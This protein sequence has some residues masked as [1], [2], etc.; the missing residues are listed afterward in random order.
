[1]NFFKRLHYPVRLRV[2]TKLIRFMA[3]W[4]SVILLLQGCAVYYKS[5][6]T[7]EQAAEQQLPVKVHF[8][9]DETV[10]FRYILQ[11]DGVFYGTTRKSGEWSKTLLDAQ[12]VEN[13]FGKNKSAST[14][15]TIGVIGVP[16]VFLVI[17]IADA[18]A[19]ASLLDAS[20]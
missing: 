9:D 6:I 19:T 1:M 18:V 10:K 4:M 20:F 13:T 2:G 14:W 16:V 5:P 7:L 8:R 11:E 3:G 17:F 15:V 12:S